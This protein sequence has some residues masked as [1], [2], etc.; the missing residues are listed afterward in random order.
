MTP[1]TPSNLH[2]R[3]ECKKMLRS[4]Y[5]QISPQITNI[6]KNCPEHGNHLSGDDESQVCIES[7]L[8]IACIYMISAYAIRKRIDD[9]SQR[10]P[11]EKLK[12]KL[13]VAWVQSVTDHLGLIKTPAGQDLIRRG[14]MK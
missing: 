4:A 14:I 6:F 11:L 12:E 9:E 5:N 13:D 1:P 8:E 2:E 3:S 10:E 7:L